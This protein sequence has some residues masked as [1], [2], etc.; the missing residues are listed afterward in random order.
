MTCTDDKLKPCSCPC[1]QNSSK[2]KQEADLSLLSTDTQSTTKLIM[3]QT[4][5]FYL[6]LTFPLMFSFVFRRQLIKREVSCLQPDKKVMPV[7]LKDTK[8]ET[9]KLVL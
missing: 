9:F 5:I 3:P 4:D 1:C 6:L 8:T 7:T 2:K